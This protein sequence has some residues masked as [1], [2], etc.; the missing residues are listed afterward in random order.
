MQT[1]GIVLAGLSI[2]GKTLDQVGCHV[3]LAESLSSSD[4]VTRGKR[5]LFCLTSGC[6]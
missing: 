4:A 5:G 1:R 3:L 2:I 6:K